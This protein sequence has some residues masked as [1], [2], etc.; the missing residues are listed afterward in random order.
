MPPPSAGGARVNGMARGCN[1]CGNGWRPPE[2][3]ERG[4]GRLISWEVLIA[5]KTLCDIF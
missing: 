5:Y 1:L 4:L 2:L 3:L